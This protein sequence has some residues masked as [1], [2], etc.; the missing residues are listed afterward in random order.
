MVS[1]LTG[2]QKVWICV[3]ASVTSF[4]EEDVGMMKGTGGMSHL[5]VVIKTMVTS[6]YYWWHLQHGL[7]QLAWTNGLQ[8]GLNLSPFESSSTASRVMLV[9]FKFPGWH[10]KQVEYKIHWENR[11][12]SALSS[13]TD[14]LALWCSGSMSDWQSEV[15]G[16][17]PNE[18]NIL[19]RGECW[20]DEGNGEYA[21]SGGCYWN[22]GHLSTDGTINMV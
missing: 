22:Y 16:S 10:V 19:F 15:A 3:P 18:F 21:P 13:F 2:N 20:N 11:L 6:P 14:T 4:S 8:P 7:I 9:P 1:H 17:S 5:V 12:N